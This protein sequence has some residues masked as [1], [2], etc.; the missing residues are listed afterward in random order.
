MEKPFFFFSDEN[1]DDDEEWD[2]EF[3]D[4]VLYFD[5]NGMPVD[6]MMDENGNRLFAYD[7]WDLNQRAYIANYQNSYGA[8]YGSQSWLYGGYSP[9]L[10]SHSGAQLSGPEFVREAGDLVDRVE[11]PCNPAYFLHYLPHYRLMGYDQQHWYFYWRSQVRAQNYLQT[12]DTYLFLHVFELIN[13]VGAESPQDGFD[14][15]LRLWRVYQLSS[16]A[17][18]VQLWT[19]IEDYA[20]AHGL[21]T[22]DQL[23]EAHASEWRQAPFTNEMIEVAS[24]RPLNEMPF[25]MIDQ[26]GDA[27][28]MTLRVYELGHGPYLE[29]FVPVALAL[30]E[31][32]I[33]GKGTRGIFD[34]YGPRSRDAGTRYV[35]E[36][37]LYGGK[38]LDIETLPARQFN[39]RP[40]KIDEIMKG[41]AKHTEN[42]LRKF[43]SVGGRVGG[44][45]LEPVQKSIIEEMVKEQF[46]RVQ[47][48]IAA[49]SIDWQTTPGLIAMPKQKLELDLSQIDAHHLDADEIRDKLLEGLEFE[50]IAPEPVTPID[51][52]SIPDESD[53][54]LETRL[55]ERFARAMTDPQWSF[56]GAM[57]DGGVNRPLVDKLAKKAG[58]MPAAFLDGINDLAY[59]SLGDSIFDTSSFPLRPYEEYVDDIT[60]VLEL[61]STLKGLPAS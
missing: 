18:R 17:V 52:I 59:D 11:E 55:F 35:F 34:R 27:R 3:D 28:L 33:K 22:L 48:A 29:W 43:L 26:L 41:V 4:G 2:D 61:K 16:N 39:E 60:A 6:Q 9:N 50:V 53:E 12:G 10:W 14:Q 7:R 5:E 32:Q 36:G 30:V 46:P 21:Y 37:A 20:L 40:S 45:K 1:E 54:A 51:Q 49:G 42:Q 13:G 25:Q 24:Q 31:K 58:M 38:R 47:M 8:T 19:W 15:L 56:L 23:F 44:Y 57:L